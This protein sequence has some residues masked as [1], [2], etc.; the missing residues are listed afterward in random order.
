MTDSERRQQRVGRLLEQ[1]SCEGEVTIRRH[2]GAVVAELRRAGPSSRIG[3]P[4]RRVYGM[5]VSEA[6]EGLYQT[7]A[8]EVRQGQRLRRVRGSH[9]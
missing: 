2:L 7:P 1:L 3:G 5:T 4:R 9:G 6:L 8:E